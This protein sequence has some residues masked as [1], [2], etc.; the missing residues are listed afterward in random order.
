VN[1]IICLQESYYNFMKTNI[2]L[3]S[4]TPQL[5]GSSAPRL[6]R[7]LIPSLCLVAAPLAHAVVLISPTLN[8]GNLESASTNWSSPGVNTSSSSVGFIEFNNSSSATFFTPTFSA[9]SGTNW[10]DTLNNAL[11]SQTITNSNPFTFLQDSVAQMTI[12]FTQWRV[13]GGSV[14][15]DRTSST[16]V[17]QFFLGST[18]L[19]TLNNLSDTNG[20][21]TFQTFTSSNIAITAGTYNFSIVTTGGAPSTIGFAVDN[22]TL[23]ATVV[24]ESSVSI[25]SLVSAVGLL[26]SRRRS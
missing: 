26:L 9:T 20:F 8:G 25:L 22:L 21:N 12:D 23:Q 19:G 2:L 11:I 1:E 15:T 3:N 4:S 17:T 6:L 5:L 13:N 16:C 18:L 14:A 7:C 24:P 10:M